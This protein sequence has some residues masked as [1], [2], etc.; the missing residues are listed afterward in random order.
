VGPN[1]G[2]TVS[3][4]VPCGGGTTQLTAV[5]SPDYTYS[6]S[7]AGIVGSSNLSVLTVS[8]GGVYTVQVTDVQT[9]CV[10]TETISVSQATVVSQFTADPTV[11]AVPLVV[12][13]T[14]QSVGA[15]SYTWNFGGLGSSNAV[16]PQ[17]E[18]TQSGTYTVTL[19]A[20]NGSCVSVYTLEIKVKE[21]GLLI[22]ELVTP[23]GDS[24]NDVWFIRGLDLY[25]DN[26]VEIYNRW[27]NLVYKMKG[28]DNTW[29]GRPNQWSMGKDRLPAGTYFYIVYLKDK[30]N[31]VHKGFLKLEY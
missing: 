23:N 31:T 15:T 20:S 17:Y 2:V 24:K 10:G 25:P 22:P 13:F 1:P 12:N 14:N 26:E 4:P 27:G 28:Y 11:G 21:G 6:W 18:F 7:G 16:S 8:A 19:T 9:G 5:S 29:D 3:G 30:D